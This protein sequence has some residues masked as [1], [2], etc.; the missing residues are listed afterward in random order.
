MTLCDQIWHILLWTVK[1]VNLTIWAVQRR[2]SQTWSQ[3]VIFV[4][5]GQW[6]LSPMTIGCWQDE[7]RL[8]AN[9]SWSQIRETLPRTGPDYGDGMMGSQTIVWYPRRK[10]AFTTW[11]KTPM[12]WDQAIVKKDVSLTP[13]S[14][15]TTDNAKMLLRFVR[16]GS[17][18]QSWCS[19]SLVVLILDR[20][21]RY[22]TIHTIRLEFV[23]GLTSKRPLLLTVAPFVQKR[24]GECDPS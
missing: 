9:L 5:D 21:T 18:W 22:A 8:E 23:R 11:R 13:L 6:P 1:I 3:C 4:S 17:E 12:K 7:N 14:K 2:I 20:F 24:T 15:W 16:Y 19:N 10:F